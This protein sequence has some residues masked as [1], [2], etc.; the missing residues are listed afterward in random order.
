MRTLESLGMDLGLA[1]SGEGE[2]TGRRASWVLFLFPKYRIGL[3]CEMHHGG[4][5]RFPRLMGVLGLGQGCGCQGELVWR[6][7]IGSGGGA[8]SHSGT[9]KWEPERHSVSMPNLGPPAQVQ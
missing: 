3:A 4:M 6:L 2:I 8:D 5:V 1:S 7:V 9:W